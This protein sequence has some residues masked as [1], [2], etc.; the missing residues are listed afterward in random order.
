MLLLWVKREHW[1]LF[2]H[3]QYNP[4]DKWHVEISMQDMQGAADDTATD[5]GNDYTPSAIKQ[6]S[7]S[8]GGVEVK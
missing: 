4:K 1:T 7:L 8:S 6:T 5:T 2:P 3:Q